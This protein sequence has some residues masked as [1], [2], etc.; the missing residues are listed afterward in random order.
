MLSADNKGVRASASL[1]IWKLGDSK[2]YGSASSASF[3]DMKLLILGLEMMLEMILGVESRTSGF[4]AYG[5]M[6]S[7]GWVGLWPF[8]VS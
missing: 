8:T 4:V 1:A 7:G 2:G 6:T 5:L 3:S